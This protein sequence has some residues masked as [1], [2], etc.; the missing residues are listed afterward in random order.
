RIG[1]AGAHG[2]SPEIIAIPLRNLGI[3]SQEDE[4]IVRTL[5]GLSQIDRIAWLLG[6]LWIGMAAHLYLHSLPD[7]GAGAELVEDDGNGAAQELLPFRTQLGTVELEEDP[8]RELDRSSLAVDLDL[9][10]LQV[11]VVAEIQK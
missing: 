4:H 7:H 10:A 6:S 11:L 2:T 9:M 3:R 8:A 5:R 1:R